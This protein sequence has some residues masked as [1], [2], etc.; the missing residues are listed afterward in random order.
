MQDSDFVDAQDR[1]RFE[2][3]IGQEVVFADYT[4]EPGRL[5][6]TYVFAPRTLRG[7]GASDRLMA[8]V[9]A[10]AR[11]EGRKILALCGYANLWLRSRKAHR[12]LL[13]A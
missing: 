1:G 8:Q 11:A 7:T 5:V 3:R 12:D 9:A 10:L 13:D 2:L 6:V 4:R